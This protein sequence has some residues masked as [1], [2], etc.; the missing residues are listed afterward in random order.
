[1]DEIKSTINGL[2]TDYT[3][4]KCKQQSW[5]DTNSKREHDTASSDACAYSGELCIRA[6]KDSCEAC[7]VFT[8]YA[9]GYTKLIL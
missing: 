2:T 4:E 8:A 7:S 1:M 3:C 9:N 6:K 5:V